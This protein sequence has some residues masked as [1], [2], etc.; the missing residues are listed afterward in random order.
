MKLYSCKVRLK[1][2][3][4]DE[5]RKAS[6]TS[7]E[8]KLLN[9]IHDVSEIVELADRALSTDPDKAKVGVLRSVEEERDRLESVYG[10][11]AVLSIFGAPKAVIG[12]EIDAEPAEQAPRKARRS[13][14]TVETSDMAA[15]AFAASA[16]SSA[17]ADAL[18]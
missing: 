3:A 12:D 4:L 17:P 2:N 6:V 9:A 11:R 10:E 1:G 8:I 14:E 15:A 18:A 16:A 13:R 7:A 5:V